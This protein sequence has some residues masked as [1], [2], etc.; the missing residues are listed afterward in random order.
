ML[1]C[2]SDN[3]LVCP[4]PHISQCAWQTLSHPH[5]AFQWPVNPLAFYNLKGDLVK[6]V[7]PVQD[8]GGGGFLLS[9]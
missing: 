9:T 3:G 6:S 1:P 5:L 2:E 8:N 4:R 7:C